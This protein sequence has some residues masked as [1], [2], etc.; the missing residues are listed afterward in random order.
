MEKVLT[1]E[2]NI[3]LQS[4]LDEIDPQLGVTLSMSVILCAVNKDFSLSANYPKGHRKPFLEWIRE[5]HPGVLLL[6]VECAAGSRQDT[7]GLMQIYKNYLFYVEFLDNQLLKYCWSN[8]NTSILQ[9][10]LFV[11]L[12]S[13]EMTALSRLLSILHIS[14][15][16][17][18]RW[19]AEKTHELKDYDWGADSNVP[20][21][22]HIV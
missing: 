5:H 15:C 20:C 17:L 10:N 12:T 19:L 22:R 6:H 18:F 7:E 11:A 9:Q 3:L 21:H 1:K 4:S 2:L 13:L 8:E 14:L 16:M